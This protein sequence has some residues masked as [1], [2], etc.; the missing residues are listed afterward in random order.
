MRQGNDANL[1]RLHDLLADRA[2]QALTEQERDELESLLAANPD[3]EASSFDRAAAATELS[4]TGEVEP[5]PDALRSRV[6]V[7]AVAWL[8]ERKGLR[9]AGGDLATPAMSARP[10]PVA[11]RPW[12]PWLVAAACLA[13]AAIGWW[14]TR[15][16]PPSSRR[17]ALMSL[18]QTK[19][20]AWESNELG[21]IGDVVWNG[22]RQEGYLRFSGLAAN[23]PTATQYQLWIF[24][25]DRKS[26][27]DNIAVDGGV[28]DVDPASGDVIVPIRAKL[29]V[30]S[31]FLFAIT[32]EPPG[33][34]VK[35][36][37]ERD[38]DR[39]RLILKAPV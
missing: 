12:V 25:E 30:G 32:T 34:V 17:A 29:P 9:L 22:E 16:A 31:P 13:V 10:R 27:S 2:T 15:E 28:F 20:V 5:M 4:W 21:V 26:Y 8:A 1:D 39:Y 6:E 18:P 33:G 37:G 24:D 14:P 35:H 3:Q 11:S 38:P 36:N 7:S 23:D 19:T